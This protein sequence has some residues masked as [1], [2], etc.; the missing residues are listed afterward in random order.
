LDSGEIETISG[1]DEILSA[2]K[3]TILM[4]K[5]TNWYGYGG[6]TASEL[7][8]TNFSAAG[9]VTASDTIASNDNDT[10]IPT[11]AAV[12]AY[13]DAS[14]VGDITG[15]TAGN[16]ISGGGTTGGVSVAI[17]TSVTADLS[18]AQTVT[19]KKTF[20]AAGAVGKL[21]VAG[22]TSGSTIIDATAAAGSGT[23]TL[24]TTGTLA[25]TGGQETLLQKTLTTP[26]INAGSDATGD[27]YYRNA[28][29]VFT[30]LAVGGAGTV[31]TVAS[32]IPSWAA[33][34]GAASVDVD[35][36][37][38]TTLTYRGSLVDDSTHAVGND[39][40]TRAL[41]TARDM[42]I[43]KIDANNEGVF[44]VIHKNGALVEVQIA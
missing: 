23:V 16:G 34:G 24:P 31:L 37:N 2:T 33:A 41:G 28:S 7:D 8:T 11:S 12:K 15:V 38:T 21:A 5:G 39:I 1:A 36:S 6:G 10:T 44:T 32:G 18:T 25:T 29:N 40:A 20:G 27:V 35:F 42:Y 4:R 13:V 14:P 22:T 19:G 26:V 17:D 43:R 30:R 3:P 9:L